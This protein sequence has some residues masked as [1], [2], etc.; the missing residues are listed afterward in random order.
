MSSETL[1]R[2]I[3]CFASEHRP[4]TTLPSD[5]ELAAR[6]SIS[7]ITVQRAMTLLK[8]QGIVERIQG[9]RSIT[10]GAEKTGRSHIPEQEGDSVGRLVGH[11]MAAI[12]RGDLIRGNAL[13]PYKRMS[14]LFRVS[15][16]TV[17]KAYRTLVEKGV[18]VR[19]G[20]WY[21]VGG[22]ISTIRSASGREVVFFSPTTRFLRELLN[23]HELAQS[24][25]KFEHE[26]YLHGVAVTYA[27]LDRFES[28]CAGWTQQGH[29]PLGLVFSGY[30]YGGITESEYNLI[31]SPLDSLLRQAGNYR[32]K[33][34]AISSYFRYPDPRVISMSATHAATVMK[35][36]LA[37]FLFKKQIRRITAFLDES[38]S[39]GPD[40]VN[41]LRILPELDILDPGISL[42]FAVKTKNLQAFVARCLT[43]TP[44]ENFISRLSKYRP[45]SFEEFR[46]HLQAV[47]SLE[48]M[49]AETVFP[50]AWLL[51][52]DDE[53]VTAI[54]W[55]RKNG[56]DIPGRA[57]IISLENNWKYPH[58]GITCC[59]RDWEAIGYLMAHA[60]IG[61][62]TPEK[63]S[64]GF[65]Q[66]PSL[67]QEKT[68]TP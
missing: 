27:T 25:R 11:F 59:N 2:H 61:D 37:E 42:T 53:A 12:G 45:Y 9:K 32:P 5:G 17:S 56:V 24:L 10:A 64:R 67:L 26:L 62:I 52:S 6:F 29:Y 13:P 38:L 23:E 51:R 47:G 3:K 30:A 44:L 21:Q 63:S 36:K 65:M 4:G 46:G 54:E 39:T 40:L 33:V 48:G 68:T 58:L 41:D 34:I 22:F 66:L 49:C 1:K 8:R 18:V 35:R 31:K 19:V 28:R 55:C 15:H 57:S 60:L 20:Q 50:A 7:R 43:E 16:S 14:A